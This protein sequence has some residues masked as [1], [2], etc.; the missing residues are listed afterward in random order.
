MIQMHLW[1]VQ[2]EENKYA[3][4]WKEPCNG[5]ERTRAKY[6]CKFVSSFVYV[7]L[8]GF[9]ALSS[10]TC[11]LICYLLWNYIWIEIIEIGNCT[12]MLYIYSI[13]SMWLSI[14]RLLTNKLPYSD[15]VRLEWNGWNGELCCI[16]ACLAFDINHRIVHMM[17]YIQHVFAICWNYLMHI[18]L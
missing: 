3:K 2:E 12:G 18:C 16:S 17:M 4:V 10:H 8:F 14:F 1:H 7:L 11:I 15:D 9:P 6:L 5:E 13:Y